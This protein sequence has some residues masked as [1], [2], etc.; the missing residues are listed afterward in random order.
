MTT[1]QAVDNTLEPLTELLVAHAALIRETSDEMAGSLF[2]ALKAIQAG[3]CDVLDGSNSKEL[4]G[5]IS[6]AISC[7]QLQDTLRQQ[8]LVLEHGLGAVA[9]AR[10]PETEAP[11]EWYQKAIE[12]IE[13]VYVMQAQH[14]L[15]AEVLGLPE[16]QSEQNA[17]DIFF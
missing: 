6:A 3:I 5:K 7:L 14:K 9:K 13:A 8:V 2:E 15:H 17:Q 10:V 12:D 4:Q 1:N 16:Q 11:A